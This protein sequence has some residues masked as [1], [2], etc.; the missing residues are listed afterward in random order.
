MTEREPAGLSAQ[1]IVARLERLPITS[2]HVRARMIAGAATFFDAFDVL[3]I[4][5]VLPVLAGAWR[6]SPSH[7]G[8]LISTGF[9]GQLAGAF[10]FGWAA[11]KFGRLRAMVYSIALFAAMSLACAFTWNYAS[12]F[13]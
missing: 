12:L 10:L 7:I 1:S 8:L 5:V 2:W 11:E 13:V 9:A 3:T 6:L 4:S